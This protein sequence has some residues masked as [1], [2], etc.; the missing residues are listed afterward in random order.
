MEGA[1]RCSYVVTFPPE[2]IPILSTSP[3][4]LH[5]HIAYP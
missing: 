4:A 2:M 3:A 1:F 5:P